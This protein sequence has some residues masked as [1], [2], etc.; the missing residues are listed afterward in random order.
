M[1]YFA[2]FLVSTIGVFVAI[3]DPLRISEQSLPEQRSHSD[4]SRHSDVDAPVVM[5]SPDQVLAR[6]SYGASWAIE[7]TPALAAFSDWTHRYLTARD[8]APLVREGI[9]LAHAR[10]AVMADLI[11]RDPQRAFE[12]TVPSSVRRQLPSV[13]QDELEKRVA[14]RGSYSTQI[15][16]TFSAAG[17][18][19]SRIR[20]S[21]SIAGISYEAHV[22]GRRLA[23]PTK[24]G[25]SLHGIVLD[26]QLALHESPVRVLEPDEA[27]EKSSAASSCPVND[28]PTLSR[29]DQ[30]NTQVAKVEA[31][32]RIWE[33]CGGLGMLEAFEQRL[34]EAE[35]SFGPLVR[36]LV[37]G[38]SRAAATDDSYAWSIGPKKILFL[39]CDFSDLPGESVSVQ[40]ARALMDGEVAPFFD[41]ISYGRTSLTTTVAEKLYR[42]P[43]PAASYAVGGSPDSDAYALA[44]ADYRLADFDRIVVTF[45]DIPNSRYGPGGEGTVSGRS[46]RVSGTENNVA[47]SWL[48][49]AHELGHTFG[50]GHENLWKVADGNPVS[51]AGQNLEYED[52]FG[53]MGSQGSAGRLGPLDRRFH[54]NAYW[55]NRLG[56]LPD[57]AVTTITTSGTYRVYQFDSRTVPAS[58]AQ[59]LRIRRGAQ[60]WYWI[61]L[62]QSFP[63][64]PSLANGAFI[65]W[66]Y[67]DGH[68]SQLI[69]VGTPGNN[70]LDAG[71]LVGS[72]LSDA[73]FG[74]SIKPIARG[75]IGAEQ[76]LDVAVTFTASQDRMVTAWGAA[77]PA[78]APKELRNVSAIAA[79]A[80][81][82]LALLLDGTVVAWG[83]NGFGQATVPAGL[84]DVISVAAGGNVSGA[85]KRDGTVVIWGD[86]TNGLTRPPAQLA[87]VARLA[88]GP[89]YAL[90]ISIT[91]T[92]V[93]WGSNS[94]GALRMSGSAYG[95]GRIFAGDDTSY[96]LG[97]RGEI[98]AFGS[99]AGSVPASLTVGGV[100]NVSAVAAGARHALALK[101]GSIVAWGD[102]SAGQTTIPSGLV[103]VVGIAAGGDHSVALMA[104]G[105]VVAWGKNGAGQTN[106]PSGIKA[107]AIAAGE[108]VS[109]AITAPKSPLSVF[110]QPES[111]TLVAGSPVTLTVSVTGGEGPVSLQ[112]RRDG[113]P[114][115]SATTQSYFI[116]AIEQTAGG[117]FD[118]VARDSTSMITSMAAVVT[119]LEVTRIANL[120]ILTHLSAGEVMTMGSTVGGAGTSGSKPLLVRAVG[121]SLALFGIM[122]ALPAARLELYN[123]QVGVGSANNWGG[124]AEHMAIFTQV[125]AFA[126]SS[127]SSRDSAIYHPRIVSG[128][129]TVQI[130]GPGG[131]A[132]AMLAELYDATPSGAFTLTTSR[133]INVSVLKQ[134]AAGDSLTVGFVVAGGGAS[135][136]LV[137]AVGPGLAPF[138]VNGAMTDPHLTL[139]K[140][141]SPS[142]ISTNNDWDGSAALAA[143]F[144]RVGAFSLSPGSRDAVILATVSPGNF[145]AQVSGTAN[146]TGMVLV[147]VYEVR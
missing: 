77:K 76:Y 99:L 72:T 91:G 111:Q 135:Q 3:V 40:R 145:T 38:P 22:Y 89:N 50:M 141:D 15:E 136:V 20:R 56:W 12:V 21:A 32:G 51:P 45:R 33:F 23:R 31:D 84:R 19:N 95:N 11:R 63:T 125:G 105:S 7:P 74:V 96:L 90:G 52:P 120:S 17:A 122:G 101:E 48:P 2:F 142:P 140:S 81:H 34:L 124:G 88:I 130:S 73:E 61:G 133:L 92:I 102:N 29:A 123:R 44:A 30:S 134:I 36:P 5:T 139:N 144:A 70:A 47:G 27:D 24:E 16:T 107:F 116:N 131:A 18:V 59:A 57:S 10:R 86:G 8:P 97:A 143:A 35:E 46:A 49:Y 137:R 83:E 68:G 58:G 75:G 121:P 128:D 114:I 42:L 127:P 98:V 64:V 147:E 28:E 54:P 4:Q 129:C 79:G 41:E 39:R 94:T 67:D 106:V 118:V 1:R 115:A 66:G 108:A 43:K 113:V 26:G 14:G 85:V 62:R 60:Q 65:V 117:S 55:K 13:V 104:D 53:F 110:A 25:A 146:S 69:D 87:N 100:S 132:G 6:F 112:W 109:L 80:Q 71:L 9:V 126:L 103:N 78:A 138:G 82:A 93:G 119:V 37:I